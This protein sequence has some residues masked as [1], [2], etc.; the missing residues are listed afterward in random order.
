LPPNARIE[1]IFLVLEP[2]TERMDRTPPPE[3]A[4]ITIV[5]DIMAPAIDQD[6]WGSAK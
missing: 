2:G 3:L 1:A 4:D 5:G 6:D